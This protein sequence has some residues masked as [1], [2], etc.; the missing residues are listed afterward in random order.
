LITNS[1]NGQLFFEIMCEKLPY[2]KEAEQNFRL[3]V[4]KS[5][6]EYEETGEC[7]VQTIVSP[8]RLICRID[9]CPSELSKKSKELKGPRID[10]DKY[11]IQKFLE[12]YNLEETSLYTKEEENSYYVKITHQS[13]SVK[14]VAGEIVASTL[15]SMVW[16]EY[17]KWNSNFRW[18]RPI[19]RIVAMFSESPVIFDSEESGLTSAPSS[20]YYLT[21][22]DEFS[23]SN[24]DSYVKSLREKNIFVEAGQRREY[25]YNQIASLLLNTDLSLNQQSHEIVENILTCSES[26]VIYMSG[27]E[28]DF[29]VPDQIKER[30]MIYHQKYVPLYDK[31]GKLSKKFLLHTNYHLSDNGEALM[32]DSCRAISARLK[33]AEHLWLKDLAVSP[34]D[35]MSN[36]KKAYLHHDLGTIYHQSKR[37]EFMVD[38][39]FNNTLLLKDAAQYLNLD[40]CMET[41]FELPSLHGLVSG[42]YSVSKC[43]ADPKVARIIHDSIYPLGEEQLPKGLTIEGA[44]LGFCSRLD[45]LVGFLGKNYLPKG[46]SDPFALRRAGFGLI[47]LGTYIKD[48]PKLEEMI[49]HSMQLYYEQGIELS[50][51][52]VGVVIN[53]L[54][55]RLEVL[56]EQVSDQY[57]KLFAGNQITWLE[58]ERL[59]HFSAIQANFPELLKLYRRL[60]GIIDKSTSLDILKVKSISKEHSNL[61]S[62]LAKDNLQVK[63]EPDYYLGLAKLIEDIL[64]K[65]K[66][67]QLPEDHKSEVIQTL[68]YSRYKLEN[69]INFQAA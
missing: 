25:I 65:V 50:P 41:V 26:P 24:F 27:Y 12:K 61:I 15:N 13:R 62:H 54:Q 1:I 58:F 53:F 46:S 60:T 44:I 39:F 4:L 32:V 63:E 55:K 22:E 36:L 21:E 17:M 8:Y 67:N 10:S 56:L 59:R 20:L 14:Q 69:Y 16:P 38:K 48:L 45:Q 47:K 57:G 18:L 49:A 68:E 3:A 30:V 31:S 34:A 43:N 23:F 35:H 42:L 52:T 40:L 29:E 6:A 33:E 2:Y 64:E 9:R 66:I 37:L 51:D 28:A 5:L 19:R 11:I 7:L